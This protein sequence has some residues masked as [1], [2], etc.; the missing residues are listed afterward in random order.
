MN[1]KAIIGKI[2]KQYLLLLIIYQL[3][4]LLFFIVNKSYFPTVTIV[5]YVKITLYGIRFDASAVFFLNLIYGILAII[6]QSYSTSKWLYKWLQY[7]FIATNTFAL[8]FNI[9]DI[10]YFPY[11]HKRISF[12]VFS[13]IGKK[14]DFIDLLPS[15]TVKYWWVLVLLAIIVILFYKLN[16]KLINPLENIN[17]Q[18]VVKYKLF[19]VV[20]AIILF[21]AVSILVY[22]G[23]FQ[24]KPIGTKE[25]IFATT[26]QNIPIVTNTTFT[27]FTSYILEDI[28]PLY[29]YKEEEL[30]KIVDPIKQYNTTSNNMNVV[31]LILES[32]GKRYTGIGGR[33]SCTPFLDSIMQQ[34]MVCT[35]AFSN[36]LISA[37][38]IP[39]ILASIPAYSNEPF[40]TSPYGTNQIDG[41]GTCVKQMGYHTSFF[42]G[43]TNGTMS[44]DVFAKNAGFDHF[45]G[46]NEYAN[47]KD[48]DGTWGIMDEPYLKYYANQLSTFKQ[49][50]CSALFTLSSHEPFTIPAQHAQEVKKY[51]KNIEKGIAYTDISLRAFFEEA[52]KQAW[53]NNTLFVFSADHSF[54]ADGDTGNYYGN[55][56]GL[57]ALPIFF[58]KHN[59]PI[60]KGNYTKP[61]QQIDILPTILQAIGYQKPFYSLGNSLF[62]TT[63]NRYL[64]NVLLPS[65]Q[66][67]IDSNVITLNDDQL[68]GMYSFPGDS[69]YANNLLSTHKSKADSTLQVLKAYKQTINNHLID[70]KMS[71]ETYR[72]KKN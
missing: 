25:A 42:H 40:T 71:V 62:D 61:F 32:F 30:N 49:P 31:V 45:Y 39:A 18:V 17:N 59:S 58:Y 13:L 24:L 41:L 38:G 48:Y 67:M 66:F 4:R 8:I 29:F 33:Q 19:K 7:F 5:E 63:S 57:F 16:N 50:F 36:A 68:T 23:G 22:R 44:F 34:S 60:F 46:R 53:F 55:K 21:S 43:G 3:V 9:A 65:F 37:D 26:N 54:L 70:N 72:K 64:F 51:T 1:L 56:M 14:A 10:A 28:N 52:K 2:L 27:I 47:D 6:V 15:Y 11:T 12:A 20:V 69:L 35:N